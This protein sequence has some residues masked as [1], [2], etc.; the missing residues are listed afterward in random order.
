MTKENVI[1][2]DDKEVKVSDLTEQQQY[3]HKQLLDLKNK[4][5]RIQFELDQVNASYSVF[6]NALA[7]SYKESVAEEDK[8]TEVN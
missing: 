8:K 2:I 5:F 1:F 4:Q 7:Q 6:Q 3:L